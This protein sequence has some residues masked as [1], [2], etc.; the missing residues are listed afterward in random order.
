MV[1]ASD[2]PYLSMFLPLSPVLFS[3]SPWIV[4]YA[5]PLHGQQIWLI[6]IHQVLPSLQAPLLILP[7]FRGGIFFYCF[8]HMCIQGLGHFSPLPLLPP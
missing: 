5:G 8:I 2:L 6:V 4:A 7:L 3:S 1:F